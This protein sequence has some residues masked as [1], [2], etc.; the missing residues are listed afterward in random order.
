MTN[1]LFKKLNIT[2]LKLTLKLI[3]FLP[4]LC[5][6]QVITVKQ[7]GTGD[8]T[9]IQ[10]GV[11]QSQD[12]DTVLVWPG[13]YTENVEIINKN[14]TLG[15]LALT[16]GDSSYMYQTRIDGNF[17]GSS[18]KVRDCLTEVTIHGFTMEHGSGSYHGP[19]GGGGISI[20]N[21]LQVTIRDCMIQENIVTGSGGGIYCEDANVFLS[22]VTV[23]SNYSYRRGG[24]I[25]QI[26]SYLQF[27]TTNLCNIYLN[28]CPNGTDYYKLSIEDS[29]H[30]VVDTF[31]VVNPDYYY[32]FSFQGWGYPG[33]DITFQV[34][35]GKIEQVSEDLYVAPWGDNDNSGLSPED[36]L[37]EISFALLKMASDC[38]SPDT[39]HLA[40][41]VYGPSNGEKFPLSLKAYASIKGESRDST[42][43]DGENEVMILNG[44]VYADHYRI[45][46]LTIM[47]GYEFFP[48]GYGAIDLIEN[49]YSSFSNILFENNYG[50]ISS[51]GSI[52]NSNNFSLH[53]VVFKNNVGGEAF[54]FGH[55]NTMV[56]FYDTLR[57][58]NCYFEGNKPEYNNPEGEFGGGLVVLGQASTPGLITGYLYNCLF[59]D[60]LTKEHPYGG[61]SFISLGL[62][63]G[64]KVNAVNCSFGDNTSENEVGANIGVT[65]N[66]DLYVYNSIMY[67]NYPAEFYMYAF[68]DEDCSLSIYHSLVSGGEAGI[69][70]LTPGN[71]VYYDVTNIDT[72]PLWDTAGPWP[73]T[74]LQGSPC[75]DA[76]TLN[77][78]P[79]IELPEYDLAGNPRVW[80]ESVDMGAYEYGPWVRVPSAPGSKFKV[81][82]STRISVSPNPFEYGTY[83][84]YELHEK[85]RLN[86]SVYSLAGRKVKTL[87]HSSG[88]PGEAGKFY[89]DGRDAQGHE[90]P[91]G[92]YVIRMTVEDR[93]LEG[94]K[95]LKSR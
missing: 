43:L 91:A 63:F 77:L 50:Y 38:V 32:L 69:Q 17:T 3:L 9:T 57:L 44:I 71:S 78:P 25:F 73:Y 83:I 52:I 90:L 4:A 15:S 67:G 51:C 10:E 26:S 68:A 14:I 2:K 56:T 89:W 30:M 75:I 48:Q 21:V 58:F 47:N 72:D 37:K 31:T 19:P 76:G 79:G 84:R 22:G 34:N 95:V 36:P 27:D 12:G 24:G 88:L 5:H 81:Q 66:S 49:N 59:E 23:R 94:V 80:G 46:D 40:N 39:I 93:L 82:G 60:N 64:S 42:I 70:I 92:T 8:A 61:P 55:A 20:E 35:T 74:L 41:G 53:D 29:V 28:Y 86:I 62:G 1:L 13:T 87:I 7:D 18:L 6:S 65:Y 16:S 45:S 11:H 85:G 33:D 54:T